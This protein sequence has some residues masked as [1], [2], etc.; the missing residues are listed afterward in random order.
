MLAVTALTILGFVLRRAMS[1]AERRPSA[2]AAFTGNSGREDQT[3]SSDPSALSTTLAP[4]F[5]D[6]TTEVGLDFVHVCG[7]KGRY[8]LPEEPRRRG[9]LYIPG[10]GS[11]QTSFG[12]TVSGPVRLL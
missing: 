1:D 9:G 7:A 11:D 10:A 5:T 4:V 8:W 12:G 6:V 2:G 3:T